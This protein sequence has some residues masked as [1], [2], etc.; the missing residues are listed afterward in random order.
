MQISNYLV[1]LT[2]APST[3]FNYFGEANSNTIQLTFS[4]KTKYGEGN[5]ASWLLQFTEDL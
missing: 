2:K 3:L 1:L 5:D 4:P